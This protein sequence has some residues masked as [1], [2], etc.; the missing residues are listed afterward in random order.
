[1]DVGVTVVVAMMASSF[2][3]INGVFGGYDGVDEANT[4]SG[5]VAVSGS[6]LGVGTDRTVMMG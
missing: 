3:M 6:R 5:V 2:G 1:M 4:G